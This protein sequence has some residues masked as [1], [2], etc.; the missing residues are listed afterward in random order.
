MRT[1]IRWPLAAAS[2]GLMLLTFA[3]MA[4]AAWNYE[5]VKWHHYSTNPGAGSGVGSFVADT[6]WIPALAARTD[7]TGAWNMLEAEPSPMGT[8][9]IGG[10]TADSTQVGAL[11]I[12]ADSTVASTLAW[13][14]TT[15]QFQVN[16]GS[17]I[18]GWTSVGGTISPLPTTTQKAAIF[19]MWQLPVATAHLG[20]TNFNATYNIF[21]P[22]VRGIV[23]WGS[24]AAVP[25][26]RVYVRKWLGTGVIQTPREAQQVN[27]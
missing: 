12:S 11:I 22:A 13:G 3:G 25:S 18:S 9:S 19:P 1:R 14:A 7:T 15:V 8:I 5:S 4:S 16:Y 20:S 21:A 10:A 26:A 23:T 6:T 24:G 2:L 17:S 27:P